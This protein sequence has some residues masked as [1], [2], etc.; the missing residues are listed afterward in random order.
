M[1]KVLVVVGLVVLLSSCSALI[2]DQKVT[3]PFGLDGKRV[4]L[5]QQGA[6]LTGDGLSAQQVSATYSGSVTAS[7]NDLDLD[8]PGG[9]SPSGI[10]ENV[11]LGVEM[12]VASS[13]PESAF[14]ASLSITASQLDFRVADG[15]GNP[16][17][18]QTF[19]SAAGLNLSFTK[20]SC[21]LASG[22]TTC[23]Y[24][25]NA[26][27]TVLVLAQLVGTNFSTFFNNILRGGSAPNTLEGTFSIT[28]SGDRLFPADSQVEVTLKTSEG[29]LA[30]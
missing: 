4:T 8:L 26:V 21:S 18:N 15:S 5:Q 17:V 14:P 27:S 7:F 28:A 1:L 29:T 23:I 9:I 6:A 3:N 30:F 11:G 22:V 24:S 25:T 20:Q 10:S 2:P 13:Q 16:T 19:K 12:K